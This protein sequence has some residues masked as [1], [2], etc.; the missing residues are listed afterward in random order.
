MA[1]TL[2]DSELQLLVQSGVRHSAGS[3][4][5]K[6]CCRCCFRCCQCSIPLTTV[7]LIV[8][9]WSWTAPGGQ[10]AGSTTVSIEIDATV[11]YLAMLVAQFEAASWRRIPR[12][13]TKAAL[14]GE[15]VMVDLAATYPATHAHRDVIEVQL[16]TEE[17]RQ[18]FLA[19]IAPISTG[20]WPR[21]QVD[22]LLPG[23]DYSITTRSR[24]GGYWTYPSRGRLV[25]GTR[26]L[27]P[28]QPRV[29][30]PRTPPSAH[31]LTVHV[32]LPADAS[33][34]TA[35][36]HAEARSVVGSGSD[37][38]RSSVAWLLPPRLLPR[39]L[40]AANLTAATLQIDKLQAGATYAVRVAVALGSDDEAAL[41]STDRWDGGRVH[42]WSDWVEY[43]TAWAAA[44]K[45]EPLVLYRVS[46][47]CGAPWQLPWTPLIHADSSPRVMAAC[48]PDWLG[49]RNSASLLASAAIVTQ[50]AGGWAG[51]IYPT[52]ESGDSR[53]ESGESVRGEN[54]PAA[55][56]RLRRERLAERYMPEFTRS[57]LSRACVVRWSEGG[58]DETQ[59]HAGT[60]P[61]GYAGYVGC[62]GPDVLH[63]ACEPCLNWIDRCV[64]RLNTSSCIDPRTRLSRLY[65]CSCSAADQ[66]ASRRRIGKLPVRWPNF[67]MPRVPRGGGPLPGEHNFLVRFVQQ[68]VGRDVWRASQEPHGP[69]LTCPRPRPPLE[70]N[71]AL[72]AWYSTPAGGECEVGVTPSVATVPRG[73]GCTW[74]Q[75]TSLRLA[76]AAAL[77]AHSFR[78]DARAPPS[79]EAVR[80]N[81]AAMQAAFDRHQPERCC[82]C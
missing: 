34:R 55:A 7:I 72:G 63:H 11:P 78:V 68:R 42:D 60:T 57:V 15:W 61:D 40:S 32:E 39:P 29:L 27:A 71:I 1:S 3:C 20:G 4:V 77:V 19:K 36:L 56:L 44:H 13:S 14:P 48:Q 53:S 46:E 12:L 22:D 37:P 65:P 47:L 69:P 18:P 73:D 8:S 10:C 17:D 26:P 9:L 58:A 24:L 35:W 70:D 2:S 31:A 38:Q 62:N 75:A 59:R 52:G 66:A 81:A 49:D 79:L 33:M 80:A 28:H 6:H 43:R 76:P 82:G 51:E 5:C 21:V 54:G 30:P 67:M 74:A 16:A 50:W 45:L 64:G 41:G 23:T 25:C